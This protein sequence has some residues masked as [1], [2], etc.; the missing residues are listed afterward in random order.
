MTPEEFQRALQKQPPAPAYLF[1]GPEA[2]QREQCRKLL[3]EKAL[4]PEE[5]QDG[6]I[7]YDLDE[8]EVGAVLDDARSFSLFAN[9]RVIWVSSAEDALP[10]RIAKDDADD[11]DG[12]TK[13]GVAGMLTNYLR[14]PNPDVVLVFDSSRYEFE[15]DDKAKIQ[16]VQKFYSAIPS[17]VEFQRLSPY[18]ARKIAQDEASRMKVNIGTSELDLLVEVLGADVS[19]VISELEKL[20]LYAGPARPITADDLSNLV[21]NAR[22]TTI[23]ALVGAVG[24]GDRAA[25]LDFLDLL[26][27]EGEYL[28]LAL[29]FLATQFRLALV[30]KEAGL[31]NAAQI[32]AHF[33]KQ[34]V[35][36]WRSR[37]EQVQQTIGAFSKE[38]LREALELIFRADRGMR[39]ARPDD[40]MVMEHFVL[41]LT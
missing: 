12:G 37:A 3:L 35:A 20:A 28:P 6:F 25:A 4:T 23:F 19:R 17:Q 2:Y 11:D 30:A 31:T 21:P 32:Q 40:R 18:Q 15:G 8:T 7:R 34:G 16:R 24:R 5:R 41:S 22:A 33:T 29:T 14:N 9:R 10:R 27:K 38:E 13:E 36:M 1:L 39:D 26:V